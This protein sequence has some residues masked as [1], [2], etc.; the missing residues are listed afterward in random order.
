[1]HAYLPE[2]R[3]NLKNTKTHSLSVILVDTKNNSIDMFYSIAKITV[4]H[5]IT[6]VLIIAIQSDFVC[7]FTIYMYVNDSVVAMFL[8]F[9]QSVISSV[10]SMICLFLIVKRSVNCILC[11]V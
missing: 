6:L 9:T 10:I 7:S 2:A 11:P 5:Q 8:S 4:H 3:D 1:M